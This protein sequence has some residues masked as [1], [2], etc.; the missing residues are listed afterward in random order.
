MGAQEDMKAIPTFICLA[1]LGC[2][3][4]DE[5]PDELQFQMSLSDFSHIEEDGDQIHLVFVSKG[6]QPE[7]WFDWQRKPEWKELGAREDRNLDGQVDVWTYPPRS[8]GELFGKYDR[9]YDGRVDMWAYHGGVIKKD[10][11][12]DGRPDVERRLG[13]QQ[14]SQ[15]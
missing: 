13:T 9:D 5:Y 7:A 3:S 4:H 11:D 1:F 2:G 10:T 14:P 12:G 6:G 15:P 8:N